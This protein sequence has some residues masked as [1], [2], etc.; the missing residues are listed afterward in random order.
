MSNLLRSKSLAW[1]AMA[2]VV[3]VIVATFNFRPAWW[4]FIDE[5]F[6]FMMVFCQLVSVYIFR[7][8]QFA[9]KKLQVIA[10]ICGILMILSIIGEYITYTIIVS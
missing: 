9:A 3:I 4:A 1:A 2:I 6:A 7:I 10:A 5:F 8:N